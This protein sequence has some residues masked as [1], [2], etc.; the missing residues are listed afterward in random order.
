MV[1][2]KRIGGGEGRRDKDCDEWDCGKFDIISGVEGKEREKGETDS[3]E[4]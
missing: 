4:A 2:G 1:E 3:A